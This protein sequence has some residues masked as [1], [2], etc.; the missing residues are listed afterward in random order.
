MKPIFLRLKVGILKNKFKSFVV[1]L[2]IFLS[3]LM[4][5]SGS[6]TE[7]SL[8]RSFKEGVSEVN[9]ADLIAYFRPIEITQAV[10]LKNIDNISEIN[11]RTQIDSQIHLDGDERE[12]LTMVGISDSEL[13]INQLKIK[14]G[15]FLKDLT[16]P[17][18]L[19]TYDFA[20]EFGLEVGEKLTL[21]RYDGTTRNYQIV[22][23]VMDNSRGL[24]PTFYP[25]WGYVFQK[26][27]KDDFM[28]RIPG[29]P[30]MN[31]PVTTAY[32]NLNDIDQS[33]ATQDLIQG[34]L[35]DQT[36]GTVF[37]L[38]LTDLKDRFD[39]I[40]SFTLAILQVFAVIA[41]LACSLIIANNI[42][43]KIITQYR[44]I[45]II[46][47]IGFTNGQLLIV[48]FLESLIF[49][50][51]GGLLGSV[52][53]VFVA[54]LPTA[55]L[56]AGMNVDPASSIDY[57]SIGTS[58]LVVL[59]LVLIA[60]I[61]PTFK[62]MRIDII[63][64]IRIGHEK[65]SNKKSILATVLNKLRSP[66]T[67]VLGARHVFEKKLISLLTIVGIGFSIA[68]LIFVFSIMNFIDDLNDPKYNQIYYDLTITPIGIE[69]SEAET[70]IS[71]VDGIESYTKQYIEKATPVS[72]A[73]TEFLV[74]G[75]SKDQ[76]LHREFKI[77]EGKY[78]TNNS[79]NEAVIGKGLANELEL[80]VGD[81]LVMNL[82][83]Q[84]VSL[85]IVGIA[86]IFND[87]GM[88]AM[89]NEKTMLNIYP[90]VE[91]DYIA[92]I[93]SGYNINSL[94]LDLEEAGSGKLTVQKYNLS[95]GAVLN[96]L[97]EVMKIVGGIL[98]IISLV[99]LT[100]FVSLLVKEKQY[101][102]G[103]LKAIG[104]TSIQLLGMIMATSLILM[105]FGIAVGLAVRQ[106]LF[107][108]IVGA[109]VVDFGR[110]DLRLSILSYLGLIGIM[111]LIALIASFLSANKV[112]RASTVDALRRL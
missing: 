6:I 49:F 66:P 72:D 21:K 18:V 35:E 2:T 84:E 64:A 79:T 14:E 46:K 5:V 109:I 105:T 94:A 61:F 23:L 51:I 30:A 9:S 76:E 43:T 100:G 17:E 38:T 99:G 110:L 13:D 58:L 68:T 90:E 88:Q 96:T 57:A 55:S 83:G 70:I 81:D 44:E 103:I 16:A 53:A 34:I 86:Q 93:E 78:Y 95:I 67:I 33:E 107:E 52:A 31:G 98:I 111:V 91:A 40:N 63:Q 112:I 8:D 82:G 77:I 71:A 69:A 27:L 54:K 29:Y 28:P 87:F 48:N 42:Y 92:S 108:L 10:E 24:Y 45:G 60:T 47:S 1:I 41:L 15:T 56:A 36:G 22:G 4:L 75:H 97:G 59:I 7:N 12:P 85:E 104:S 106:L 101:E 32:I 62:A 3:T 73:A 102:I 25:A 80:E 50:I 26:N 20:Q 74:W 65:T 11:F 37:F 19:L 89:V 39:T